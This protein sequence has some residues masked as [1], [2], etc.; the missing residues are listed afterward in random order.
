MTQTLAPKKP[1]APPQLP[2]RVMTRTVTVDK[3]PQSLPE[4]F[5]ALPWWLQL[6]LGLLLAALVGWTMQVAQERHFWLSANDQGHE[7][8]VRLTDA[9]SR[10]GWLLGLE[11]LMG[12]DR[13]G[14]LLG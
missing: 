8:L 13:Q 14:A 12:V 4:L 7:Q 3:V 5:K 1:Q 9:S 10:Y 11:E 2:P 6:V